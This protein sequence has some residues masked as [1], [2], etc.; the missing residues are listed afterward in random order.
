MWKM[1]PKLFNRFVNCKIK[2]KD[3]L[4]VRARTETFEDEEKTSE[5]MNKTCNRCSQWKRNLNTIIL[6]EII[7]TDINEVLIVLKNL[8]VRKAMD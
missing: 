8:Y 4:W 7:L 5:V 1:E 2:I 3:I 6:T